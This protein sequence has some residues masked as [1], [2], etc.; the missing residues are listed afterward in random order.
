MGK[1]PG[2]FPPFF[3]PSPPLSPPQAHTHSEAVVFL[4]FFP[5]RTP[6][7]TCSFPPFPPPS[8][9]FLTAPKE[10][11][12]QGTKAFFSLFPQ[13]SDFPDRKQTGRLMTQSLLPLYLEGGQANL[14]SPPFSMSHQNTTGPSMFSKSPQPSFPPFR[15]GVYRL[16]PPPFCKTRVGADHPFQPL[17]MSFC[18]DVAHQHSP[19]PFSP[20][21]GPEKIDLPVAQSLT[22]SS[23]PPQGGREVYLFSLFSFSHIYLSAACV[24]I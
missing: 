20:S 24:G 2:L 6:T 21:Q 9:F 22:F 16:G 18:H 5:V 10:I 13:G 7:T 15:A 12:A 8:P 4:F 19:F 1:E 11:W 14:P 17:L 23:P 3:F